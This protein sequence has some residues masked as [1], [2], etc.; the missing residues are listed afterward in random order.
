MVEILIKLDPNHI[1]L[2]KIPKKRANICVHT[3]GF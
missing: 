2:L 3:I 1:Y